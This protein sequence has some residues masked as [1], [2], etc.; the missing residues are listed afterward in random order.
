MEFCSHFHRSSDNISTTFGTT[1]MD[2]FTQFRLPDGYHLIAL[3]VSTVAN[4]FLGMNWYGKWFGETWVKYI[5]EDK[6]IKAKDK[7]EVSM[8]EFGEAH[9]D[10]WPYPDTYS[11]AASLLC[12]ATKSWFFFHWFSVLNVASALDALLVGVCWF[13]IHLVSIHQYF[14]QGRKIQLALIDFGYELVGIIL[15]TMIVSQLPLLLMA[16]V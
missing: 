4:V 1:T 5:C 14:W 11:Y 12:N 9:K 15:T 7:D 6:G 16:V 8:K 10:R 3:I 13:T 2:N